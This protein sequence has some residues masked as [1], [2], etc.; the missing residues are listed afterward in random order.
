[1]LIYRNP[2]VL[3]F[4]ELQRQPSIC[5][6]KDQPLISEDVES[7]IWRLAEALYQ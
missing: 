3:H 7:N 1:M 2:E 6:D 4:Q 5:G